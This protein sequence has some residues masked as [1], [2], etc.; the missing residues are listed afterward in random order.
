MPDLPA[1][2][3]TSL[4]ER[5]ADLLKRAILADELQPGD[6]MPPERGLAESLNVSR[7]VLREALS[8]LIGE[9][10]LEAESPRVLR[11]LPFERRKVVTSLVDDGDEELPQRSLDE[12]RV[13]VEVGMMGLVAERATPEH[14]AAL[15]GRVKE[16]E[17][18]VRCGEPFRQIDVEFHL[19]LVNASGNPLLIRFLPLIEE[20]VRQPHIWHPSVKPNESGLRVAREHRAIV[21]AVRARD[22][23]LARRAMAVHLQPYLDAPD[24]RQTT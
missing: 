18:H 3:R 19:T 14:L 24:R 4:A 22:P 8:R 17:E 10:I 12:V 11:V 7:T 1:V 5:T 21:D 2:R 15:E 16:V 23:D 20:S 6:Q 9:G 13:I